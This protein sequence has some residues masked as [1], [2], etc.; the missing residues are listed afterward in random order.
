MSFRMAEVDGVPRIVPLWPAR[1]VRL[2]AL[3][4]AVLAT[5]A[6]VG[7]GCGT[8]SPPPQPTPASVAAI[9]AE[10]AAV[11]NQ[12]PVT[13]WHAGDYGVRSGCDLYLNQAA[14]RAAGLSTASGALGLGGTAAAGFLV[15]G[16]NPAGAAAAGTLAALGQSFLQL[17]QNSGAMPYTAAT[18]V[19]ID[20]AM[21]AYEAAVDAAPPTDMA[22]AM[23][24][25]EG[26]W[27]I[28]TPSGYAALATEAIRSATVSAAPAAAANYLAI[29]PSPSITR[30]PIVVN[31]R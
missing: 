1:A 14:S 13:A 29:S 6:V 2:A 19:I 22:G 8:V 31:G 26:V 17:F 25:I 9:E 28:C 7:A 20:K 30:P 3:R 12:D 15:A 10:I 23:N 11:A 24:A 18:A 16:G 21:G 4:A 5:L 27:N